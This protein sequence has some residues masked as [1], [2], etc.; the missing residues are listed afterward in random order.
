VTVIA[1]FTAQGC[2]V[3]FGD[4]LISGPGETARRVTVPTVGDVQNIHDGWGWSVRALEQKV[5]LISD[6]CV[7]AWAGSEIR[8]RE[9]VA[10]LRSMASTTLLT[11]QTVDA[12]LEG[13]PAVR[14][15]GTSFI[16]WIKEEER[17]GRFWHNAELFDSASFGHMYL[18][19]TG[20]D[21]IKE[22]DH[23]WQ[24]DRLAVTGEV[25][26]VARAAATGLSM[27]AML[28]RSEFHSGYDAPTLRSMFGGGYEVATF[29]DGRFQEIGD[30][31]FIVWETHVTSDRVLISAPQFILKQK[32]LGD[33]LLLRSARIAVEAGGQLRVID[34]QRHAI[35]PMYSSDTEV[36]EQDLRDIALD[37]RLLCHS[38]M[39]H[40][41]GSDS[42][43][44]TKV[45][46]TGSTTEPTMT[47][48]DESGRLVLGLNTS[49]LDEVEKELQAGFARRP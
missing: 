32:Y 14:K 6:R 2:P 42:A 48:R 47:F 16:G 40:A 21:A 5:V 26:P 30:M 9:A 49:F 23:L 35:S 7:L 20:K 24:E 46:Q 19:G 28:L 41:P 18:Q 3:L 12:F 22:I 17:F 45:Q 36:S 44:F 13:H 15:Y 25:P 31:T 1:A 39:V 4:L 33:N 43:I 8:A 11:T 38:F 29:F 27:A 37:S 34:Q 10:D